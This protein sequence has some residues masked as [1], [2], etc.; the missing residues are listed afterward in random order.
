MFGPWFWWYN[1][2]LQRFAN[3]LFFLGWKRLLYPNLRFI[4]EQKLQEI[5]QPLLSWN[6]HGY[7]LKGLLLILS[8]L[9]FIHFEIQASIKR[10]IPK[11]EILCSLFMNLSDIKKNNFEGKCK[12][13]KRNI[14]LLS[15]CEHWDWQKVL[16][17]SKAFIVVQGTKFIST[18]YIVNFV[19][20]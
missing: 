4:H 18:F 2:K 16:T 8:E 6:D 7:W 15:I 5:L 3:Q 10:F 19:F 13:K 14:M 12:K 20:L 17:V 9:L 1:W 11:S